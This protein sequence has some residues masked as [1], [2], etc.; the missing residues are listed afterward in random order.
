MAAV[1]GVPQRVPGD[2]HLL[3][4]PVVVERRPQQDPDAEVDVDEVVGDQLAIDDHAGRDVHRL[5]P[6]GHVLVLEVAHV[7]VLERAPAAQQRAAETDLL[8]ARERLVEEVEEIIVHRHDAL[9]ELDVTHEA[10]EV[11]GEELDGRG[12]PDTTRV[13]RRGVDVPALH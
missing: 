13:Q 7:R 6:A 10:S 2:E 12:R 11:V 3:V 1:D 5:A 8:V 4:H 9:H